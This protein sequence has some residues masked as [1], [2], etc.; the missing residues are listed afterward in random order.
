MQTAGP[1]EGDAL[2]E[3]LGVIMGNFQG[4]GG[5]KTLGHHY[6]GHAAWLNIPKAVQVIKVFVSTLVV[7]RLTGI[8]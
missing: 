3:S 8:C 1:A 2:A 6:R 7:R 4:Q 5:P